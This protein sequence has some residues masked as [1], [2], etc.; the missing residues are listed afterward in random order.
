MTPYPAR[1]CTLP[2]GP[3]FR[4]NVTFKPLAASNVTFKRM[5]RVGT[6]GGGGR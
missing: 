5:E 3:P 1:G 2:S 4:L 6:G